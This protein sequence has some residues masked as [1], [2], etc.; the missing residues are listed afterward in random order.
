M[1]V[2]ASDKYFAVHILILDLFFIFAAE[3]HSGGETATLWTEEV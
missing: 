1:D 2:P 3:V